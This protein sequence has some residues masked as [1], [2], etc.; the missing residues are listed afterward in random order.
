M[1]VKTRKDL[2]IDVIVEFLKDKPVLLEDFESRAAAK[3]FLIKTCETHLSKKIASLMKRGDLKCSNQEKHI[4]D[5]DASRAIRKIFI[6]NYQSIYRRLIDGLSAIEEPGEIIKVTDYDLPCG[7][8]EYMSID[9]QL[10]YYCDTCGNRY[11]SLDDMGF[12]EVNWKDFYSHTY[13]KKSIT[14]VTSIYTHVYDKYDLEQIEYENYSIVIECDNRVF[15]MGVNSNDDTNEL[16]AAEIKYKYLQK[17]L[18]EPVKNKD[19]LFEGELIF[20]RVEK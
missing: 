11:Y 8:C 5:A 19:H 9:D 10:G 17:L 3:R 4:I 7:I 14:Y 20:V 18:H 2:I 12:E 15:L 1:K 6:R 13:R 16:I